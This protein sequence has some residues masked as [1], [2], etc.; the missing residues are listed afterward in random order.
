MCLYHCI[1]S[2][3]IKYNFP[4]VYSCNINV[5]NK[6]FGW[7]WIKCGLLKQTETFTSYQEPTGLDWTGAQIGDSSE[8]VEKWAENPDLGSPNIQ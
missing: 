4:I 3:Y 7:T 2:L 5:G 6:W 1:T 8:E